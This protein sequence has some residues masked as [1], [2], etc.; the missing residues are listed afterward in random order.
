M[1]Q[2]DILVMIF[3]GLWAIGWF[4]VFV[5]VRKYYKNH[6]TRVEEDPR[7]DIPGMFDEVCDS[8]RPYIQLR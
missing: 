4:V 7:L 1:K 6:R 8:E 2:L 3:L 5:L